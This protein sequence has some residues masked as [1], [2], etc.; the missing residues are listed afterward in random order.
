MGL[1]SVAAGAWL[2]RYRFLFMPLTF[3]F[4]AFSFWRTYGS[5]QYAS[6]RSKVIL[7]VTASVS[8][9]LT[10]YSLLK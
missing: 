3:G 10:V 5:G 6:K 7:W 9:T 1:G 8:I 2:T 4:L